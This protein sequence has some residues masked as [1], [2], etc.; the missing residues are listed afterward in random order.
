MNGTLCTSS[1]VNEVN[2]EPHTDRFTDL[3][4]STKTKIGYLNIKDINIL[5]LF[6]KLNVIPYNS[7]EDGII[8]KQ[9]KISIPLSE[10]DEFNKNAQEYKSDS[11]VT[12]TNKRELNNKYI[13][14]L[15]IGLSK[16][17]LLNRP[18]NK[19]AFYNCFM[20]I[21]R[22]KYKGYFR[23]I[24]A[25]VFN[26]GKLSFPGMITDELLV[27]TT[28]TLLNIL[29]RVHNY[30][31]VCIRDKSVHTVLVNSNFNC[32]FYIDRDKLA[33]ILKSKYNIHVYYDSCSYPGIQCK[34]KIENTKDTMSFMIFR[35][36]SILIVGKCEDETLYKI[37]T[38]IKNI[39]IDEY[40]IISTKCNEIKKNNIIKKR[41]KKIVYVSK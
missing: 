36:G 5:E 31:G 38:F 2:D 30:K 6:W 28:N 40:N 32:G 16:K 24:N 23:E 8:K 12:I 14:K 27:L 26:T 22:I 1:D 39:L 13:C 41:K 19:G 35:T 18:K 10:R 25:K 34:Y 15:N 9:I 29:N 33:D 11:I 3:N 4:I 20:I 37:Y 17:D 7:R 21:I